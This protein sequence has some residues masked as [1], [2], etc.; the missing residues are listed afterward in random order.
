[1]L[2]RLTGVL[3][4]A[5]QRRPDMRADDATCRPFHLALVTAN[6]LR[7]GGMQTFTL[8]WSSSLCGGLAVTVTLSVRHLRGHCVR[9]RSSMLTG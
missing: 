7:I 8:S 9:S 5:I 1:M 4:P 3:Q 2:D 6:P